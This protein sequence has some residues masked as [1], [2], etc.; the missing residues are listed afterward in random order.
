MPSP[1]SVLSLTLLVRLKARTANRH[2]VAVT[3][4]TR[5]R[6]RHVDDLVAGRNR[7]LAVLAA[8]AGLR[9][10]PFRIL[11]VRFYGMLVSAFSLAGGVRKGEESTSP[12]GSGGISM[13]GAWLPGSSLLGSWYA[14]LRACRR[15]SRQFFH[16]RDITLLSRC[17]CRDNNIAFTHPLSS[18]R[19]LRSTGSSSSA[20]VR[21][22]SLT[23]NAYRALHTRTRFAL[24]YVA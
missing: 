21:C 1:S 19:L 16:S 10:Q 23:H 22:G 15:R 5:R 8:R 18:P 12:H 24:W 11:S 7:R 14:Y 2:S 4:A 13:P 6:Q 17:G 9:V 20:M 3:A